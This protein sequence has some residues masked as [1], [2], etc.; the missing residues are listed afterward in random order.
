MEKYAKPEDCNLGDI[1]AV[2]IHGEF[3][4]EEQICQN[5]EV[6]KALRCMTPKAKQVVADG[7]SPMPDLLPF[8]DQTGFRVGKAVS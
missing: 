1:V 5:Y 7:E 4:H 6:V 3:M 8:T 2:P